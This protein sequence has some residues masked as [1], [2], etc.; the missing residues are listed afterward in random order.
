M[1]VD[2]YFYAVTLMIIIFV[3]FQKWLAFSLGLEIIGVICH[4]YH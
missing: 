1:V 2:A 3:A 4:K